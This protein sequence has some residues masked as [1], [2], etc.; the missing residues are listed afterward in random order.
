MKNIRPRIPAIFTAAILPVFLLLLMSGC[1]SGNGSF[2][3]SADAQQSAAAQEEALGEG[4]DASAD[5]R[6]DQDTSAE[7]EFTDVYGNVHTLIVD[8]TAAMH[9]YDRSAFAADGQKMTYTDSEHYAYRLGIDVS[10]YQGEIDWTAVK[11]AGYDFVLIRIGLRG[12]GEAG[13]LAEDE[14]FAENLSG[15][16]AAGL[17]AGVYFY[18]QAVSEEEAAEE[19]AFVLEILDGAQLEL[20]V[21]YDPEYVLDEEGNQIADARTSGLSGTQVT[22]DTQTFCAAIEKAG[23][24]AAFYSNMLSESEV[25]DMTVLSAYTVWYAD[26]EDAPQTPYAFSFWQY[27]ESGTVDGISGAV[28]LNIQ[29]LPTD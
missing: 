1:A 6:T 25:F 15:A 28:D 29:L 21:V 27:S 13:N 12:Y 24:K 5:A 4:Q 3:E 19:A 11:A 26:Y 20:P 23:Y 8:Q 9:D 14:M 10:Y 7:M 18:A 17:D 22:A 2:A 16:Q